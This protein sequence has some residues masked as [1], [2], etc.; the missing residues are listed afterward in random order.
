MKN[1]FF[2]QRDF[3]IVGK[4]PKH[5]LLDRW[6]AMSSEKR[7]RLFGGVGSGLEDSIFSRCHGMVTARQITKLN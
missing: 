4:N 2:P 5:D 1:T 6:I 3:R 7:K